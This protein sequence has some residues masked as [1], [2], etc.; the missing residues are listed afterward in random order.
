MYHF[1][2]H[3]SGGKFSK[4]QTFLNHKFGS[5]KAHVYL[6]AI[7]GG[8]LVAHGMANSVGAQDALP[9]GAGQPGTGKEPAVAAADARSTFVRDVLPIFMGKCARCHSAQSVLPN[10][11]DYKTAFA[12]R[13]EIKRRV[14]D[15]WYGHY[16]KQSMPAGNSPEAAS[17]TEGERAIIKDWVEAGGALGVPTAE[18]SPQSKPERI[19]QG[20]R[21]FA[22]VC[23]PCHQT[24]GEGVPGKFPPLAKS[25]FLNADKKRAIGVLLHGRQG[26]I[27]VNG[28]QFNNSMPSFP[29]SDD[30][31]ASALTF[32]YNSFGNSGKEVT[33]A[34]VKTLRAQQETETPAEAKEVAHA[35]DEPSPFE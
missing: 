27:T 25:D 10:W 28:Q 30:Q 13:R 5:M 12:D 35:H 21:L 26:Q 19:E 16:Y 32:V 20:K 7:T 15:S 24:T 4:I 22:V 8:L 11:L 14:W 2:R 23:T 6:L 29:L 18:G 1:S 9:P 33:A 34:E 31:I 3:Q 17:L